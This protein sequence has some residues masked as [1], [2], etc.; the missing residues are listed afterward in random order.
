MR[1]RRAE[2]SLSVACDQSVWCLAH[3]RDEEIRVADDGKHGHDECKDGNACKAKS[4][5]DGVDGDHTGVGVSIGARGLLRRS[6]AAAPLLASAGVRERIL[7]ETRLPATRA[8]HT[9]TASLV[10]P[11]RV[12]IDDRDDELGQICTWPPGLRD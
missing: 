6:S 10:E 1:G 5:E 2:D 9:R 7:V 8:A 11:H 3:F 12:Q 4:P